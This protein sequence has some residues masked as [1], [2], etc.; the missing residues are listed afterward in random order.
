MPRARVARGGDVLYQ[1][2]PNASKRATGARAQ[3]RENRSDNFFTFVT[4]AMHRENPH[5]RHDA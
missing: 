4:Q 2:G 5:S 3:G 1:N